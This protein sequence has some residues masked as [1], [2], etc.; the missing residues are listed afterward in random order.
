NGLTGLVHDRVPV[1]MGSQARSILLASQFFVRQSPVP[2]SIQ[3]YINQ[4]PFNLGPFR[5]TPFLMDHSAFDAYSLLVE[6]DDKRV[7]YSGDLR[8]H[9]RKA[10]LVE[11][12]LAH[13]PLAIDCLLLEGTTLS[14]TTEGQHSPETE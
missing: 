1:F 6:A 4:T 8:A 12:L 3:T 10:S 7:F 5:I 11:N 2:P 9:G 13:P 14:R